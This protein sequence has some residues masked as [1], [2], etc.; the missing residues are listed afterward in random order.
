MTY[1]DF[2]R[3][4]ESFGL[5]PSNSPHG[6]NLNTKTRTRLS[7]NQ[8]KSLEQSIPKYFVFFEKS[9]NYESGKISISDILGEFDSY[10]S[11]LSN[12]E[13]NCFSHQSD[14]ISSLL[15]ELLCVV[16]RR[17]INEIPNHGGLIVT[18]QKDIVIECNFDVSSGGRIID[19]KKR[20]DVAVLMPGFLQFKETKLDFGIPAFCAEIKTN[21]DKNMLSGIEASV[22]TLKRTF[23]RTKYYAIG[24]FSDF[25]IEGQN[26]AATGI[27]EILILRQQKR[28]IVRRT[29][30]AR[31]P[32][33]ES[34]MI[35]FIEEIR[36]H[37]ISTLNCQKNLASRLS[38][39]RLI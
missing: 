15:P 29:P 26:Y 30:G 10:Y 14:F 38:S 16:L 6:S 13:I 25:L 37:L 28:S 32:L 34:L 8:Q 27:D 2:C 1:L 24:E 4:L 21:I 31:N 9:K 19:K 17:I 39:G 33:S 20:M 18:S 3:K 22:E 36:S 35:T 5:L 7:L 11:F 12:P 23:P